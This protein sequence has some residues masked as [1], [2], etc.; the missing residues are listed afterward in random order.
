MEISC[1]KVFISFSGS[2]VIESA[3]L[4]IK[5]TPLIDLGRFSILLVNSA[6]L[7]VH[8]KSSIPFNIVGLF[9]PKRI[10]LV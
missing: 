6:A 4:M 2:V 9:D 5:F 3:H 10:M 7:T 8:F 1:E